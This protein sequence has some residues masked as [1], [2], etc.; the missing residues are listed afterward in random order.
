MCGELSDLE[1]EKF[2]ESIK[3]LEA[4]EEEKLNNSDTP[5]LIGG[6]P[7]TKEEEQLIRYFRIQIK[8]GTIKAIKKVKK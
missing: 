2:Y 3:Q 4:S 5:Y 7:I 6:E 1:L 8:R